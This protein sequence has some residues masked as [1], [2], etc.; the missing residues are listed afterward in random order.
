M[1]EIPTTYCPIC[2]IFQPVKDW[3]DRRG[4][5]LIELKHCGHVIQHSTRLEWNVKRAAA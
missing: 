4:I 1:R 3:H 5:L 2:K